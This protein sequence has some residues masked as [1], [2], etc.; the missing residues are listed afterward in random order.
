M[1]GQRREDACVEEPG[2]WIMSAIRRIPEMNRPAAAETRL[3]LRPGTS[4]PGLKVAEHHPY[5]EVGD[6]R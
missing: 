6:G 1:L 5:S 2:V 4:G 3:I